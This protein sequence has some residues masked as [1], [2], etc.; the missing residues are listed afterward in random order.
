M[1]N[2]TS[3]DLIG[4]KY[5]CA[6]TDCPSTQ[7]IQLVRDHRN[8]KIKF[9]VEREIVTILAGALRSSYFLLDVICF[10]LLFSLSLS[11]E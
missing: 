9:N 3:D 10:S 5:I 6:L 11:R 1:G 2:L 8:K 4:D 7:S